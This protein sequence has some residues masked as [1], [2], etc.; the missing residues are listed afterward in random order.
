ML[1]TSPLISWGYNANFFCIF[2]SLHQ[3]FTGI[4]QIYEKPNYGKAKEPQLFNYLLLNF[5]RMF[6]HKRRK[7]ESAEL[8]HS[9]VRGGPFQK[10]YT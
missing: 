8:P 2:A 7:E 3:E 1:E 5:A 4:E 6:Q 10:S 9:G